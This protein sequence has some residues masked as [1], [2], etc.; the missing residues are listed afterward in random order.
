MSNRRNRA[1]S[2]PL[3]KPRPA[4]V[5]PAIDLHLHTTRMSP[6]SSLRPEELADAA[7][8]TRLWA[9]C[10]TEHDGMWD[11]QEM[12]RFRD[13][14]PIVVLHG[15]EVST[16]LGHVGVFGL[17]RYVGGI[18]RLSEIRRIADAEDAIL[19]ANHPFRYRLDPRFSRG[20]VMFDPERPELAVGYE[21]FAMVDAIEVANG[22]CSA[23]ENR[24]ALAVARLL[25]QAEVGGSDSHS[26]GSV[27]C[28][29]T[30]FEAPVRTERELIE[31]IKGHRCRAASR[32]GSDGTLLAVSLD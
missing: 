15:M 3:D 16:D 29:A 21:L 1:D 19:I 22:A 23:Q 5:A 2:S 7:G 11:G 9:V 18:H 32:A 10:V 30:F 12:A 13:G 20:G 6:D 26:A 28:A 31:A 25:G 14:A 27:G 4:A 24:F 8:L 17:D